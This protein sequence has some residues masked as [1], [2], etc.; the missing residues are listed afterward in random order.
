MER[1]L[2]L[3]RLNKF[4][5]L[6]TVFLTPLIGAYR[7]FGYEQAKV[8]FFIFLISL[9]GL[10]WMGKDFVWSGI[11][12]AGGI[13]ILLLLA[14]SLSGVDPF[15]SIL[16]TQ[17]YFQ[18][19]ILYAYLF[20]F[21]LLVSYSKI[22]FKHWA[23]VLVGSATLVSLLAIKDWVLINIFN[24]Q[25]PNYAGRVV[26]TFGQP[27]FYAG[28]L[29][30]TLPFFR[31][32]ISN[33][34]IMAGFLISI[35][36]IILSESRVAF[37]ILS[38][39]FLIWL[40]EELSWKRLMGIILGVSLLIAFIFSI[41]F[42]AGFLE[43]EIKDVSQTINPD[44]TK[45]GVEKRYYF[46]PILWELILQRPI[47]GYGLENIA[48]VFSQYFETNKHILFEENL[49]VKP[50]LFGLK[51]LYLDRSHNYILDLLLFSGILGLLGWF[52]LVIMLFKKLKQMSRD[53]GTNVLMVSLILYLIWI[54]FQN[55][56]V[57]HLIY[58]W[59]I[60]GL[61]DSDKV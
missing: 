61:V 31:L 33:W 58:F 7:G 18:G 48:P 20:L 39:L 24:Q 9:C 36:A 30:L 46:W 43:K 11:S 23:Y 35:L 8:F 10:L 47:L 14:A 57:V 40:S 50:Y 45:I 59:L 34:W 27:N 19:A 29:L 2:Q 53:R 13:F 16:G 32:F 4:L 26:S 41:F 38:I 54:Q 5:L 42:G 3:K 15:T 17:V 37:L 44:L 1:Y 60:I 25:I 28:F 52:G 51:D 6:L 55:Q 12:K 56:S 22:S 49:K 21:S